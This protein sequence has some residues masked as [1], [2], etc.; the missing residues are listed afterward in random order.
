MRYEHEVSREWLLQRQRHLTA[1]DIRKMLADLRKLRDGKTDLLH[2]RSFAKVYG[3][4]RNLFPDTASPSSAAARGHFMEP[5]AVGEWAV[6]NGTA[7]YHWDDFLLASGD[8]LLA[9]SPDALDVP[10]PAGTCSFVDQIGRFQDQD[11]TWH[12]P[13][14]LLEVKSYDDGAHWQRKL[15]LVAGVK[16]DERWQ[17]AVAMCVCPS[18]RSGTVMWYAPQCRDWFDVTYGRSELT[19]E[20]E[21]VRFAERQWAEF[22]ALMRDAPCNRTTRDEESLR[23]IYL[24]EMMLNG[25]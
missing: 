2:C 17:V 12:E 6:S 16:A 4:K 5:H 15:D 18:I 7:M 19:A 22:V 11:G 3:S 9:F 1:S 25:S 23:N 14:S 24:T 8:T 10:Q 21:T 13:K 20:M